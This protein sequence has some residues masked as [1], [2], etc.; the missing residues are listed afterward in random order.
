MATLV[1]SV[2]AS[3]CLLVGLVGCGA[4]FCIGVASKAAKGV[5]RYAPTDMGVFELN[6]FDRMS[7]PRAEGPSPRRSQQDSRTTVSKELTLNA[8]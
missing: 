3:G 6:D 1:W 2:V 8:Q 4:L 5:G 7:E